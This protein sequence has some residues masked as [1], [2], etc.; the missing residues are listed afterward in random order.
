MSASHRNF[1]Q[2]TPSELWPFVADNGRSIT[3]HDRETD[4]AVRDQK[5]NCLDKFVLSSTIA[6]GLLSPL[7]HSA[8][9]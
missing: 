1:G 6:F 5:R 9:N 4:T 2:K 7:L 8:Q 3:G